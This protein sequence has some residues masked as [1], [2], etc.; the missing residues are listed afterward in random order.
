MLQI[1]L[2]EEAKITGKIAALPFQF[3]L[4]AHTMPKPAAAKDR[5]V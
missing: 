5:A 3:T 4:Q 2:V 1:P